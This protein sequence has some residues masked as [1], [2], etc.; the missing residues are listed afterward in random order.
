[1]RTQYAFQRENCGFESAPRAQPLV[2]RVDGAIDGVGD[3]DAITDRIMQSLKHN[4]AK[5]VS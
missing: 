2:D 3:I 5:V 4:G 1:M